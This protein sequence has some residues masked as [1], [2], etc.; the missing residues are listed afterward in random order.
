MA[1]EGSSNWDLFALALQCISWDSSNWTHRKPLW[2]ELGC[3]D[4]TDS[5]SWLLL[6]TCNLPLGGCIY[7]DDRTDHLLQSL[8]QSRAL[9]TPQNFKK[10]RENNILLTIRLF[11]LRCL[12]SLLWLEGFSAWWVNTCY[13]KP[14]KSFDGYSGKCKKCGSRWNFR[15]GS[16]RITVIQ[17]RGVEAPQTIKRVISAQTP[18]LRADTP[19]TTAPICHCISQTLPMNCFY[20]KYHISLTPTSFSFFPHYIIISPYIQSS[21]YLLICSSI[22][23]FLH[24]L[25]MW[26]P[27]T[28][29]NLGMILNSPHSLPFTGWWA[30]EQVL[31]VL[32]FKS[33]PFVPS[34]VSLI[35]LKWV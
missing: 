34:S 1:P 19:F 4:C 17:E 23:L 13:F 24:S 14:T 30:P 25:T 10:P 18:L 31:P 21:L 15:N 32:F 22:Q 35:F 27:N 5:C 8:S 20:D 6:G 33:I 26:A 16:F 29:Q 7:S 12:V 3:W 9:E 28:Q 2:N 11:E